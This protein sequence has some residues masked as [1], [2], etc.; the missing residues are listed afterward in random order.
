MLNGTFE[1][2]SLRVGTAI[3]NEM[4]IER[5]RKK[6]KGVLGTIQSRNKQLSDDLWML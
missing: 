6:E 2:R 4:L 3:G 1:T 5:V